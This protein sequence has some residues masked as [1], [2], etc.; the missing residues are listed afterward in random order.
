MLSD[1]GPRPSNRTDQ[2]RRNSIRRG[3]E[4]RC[5]VAGRA[6]E[7]AGRTR[8]TP[9]RSPH[10]KRLRAPIPWSAWPADARPPRGRRALPDTC[11]LRS[12]SHAVGHERQGPP[13]RHAM[14]R[15]HGARAHGRRARRPRQVHLP[16]PPGGG[17]TTDRAC[18]RTTWRPE[19][20]PSPRASTVAPGVTSTASNC[21]SPLAG[22]GAR[23][24]GG[25]RSSVD[26]TA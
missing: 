15:K 22:G 10:A 19:A 23:W 6:R 12:S 26:L 16:P 3:A 20:R 21:A 8:P 2:E 25:P 5:R 4:D 13:W 24:E 11:S 7:R 17:S 1:Q 14:P 9:P 18:S